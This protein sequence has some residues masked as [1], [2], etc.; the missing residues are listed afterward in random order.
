MHVGGG[1][2]ID[3]EIDSDC[4]VVM[5]GTTPDVGLDLGG[6]ADVVVPTND[7]TLTFDV[8]QMTAW[9]AG[10]SIEFLC[11]TTQTIS[12]YSMEILR[13]DADGRRYRDHRLERH[14]P[15]KTCI[16]AIT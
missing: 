13:R 15:G 11:P 16:S 2:T 10:D 3:G 1:C 7:A 12:S 9:Q 5:D 4:Y 8:D 6:R 14:D